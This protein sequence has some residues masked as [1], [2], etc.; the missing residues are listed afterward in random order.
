MNT[1]QQALITSYSDQLSSRF[2]SNSM[3]LEVLISLLLILVLIIEVL[4][5]VKK[6]YEWENEHETN[7]E[8][9]YTD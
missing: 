8:L 5:F 9:K 7:L 1:S 4:K 2:Y 6:M 3:A